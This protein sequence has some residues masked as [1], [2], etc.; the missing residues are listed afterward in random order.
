[1][2]LEQKLY[3]EYAVTNTKEKKIIPVP[4]ITI[5]IFLTL[6]QL[7]VDTQEY[8]EWIQKYSSENRFTLNSYIC[9]PKALNCRLIEEQ[10]TVDQN[11]NLE[12][13]VYMKSSPLT[14]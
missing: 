12:N 10:T 5:Q 9:W 11:T 1:M 6:F 13:L 2:A 14:Y 4:V 3:N 8:V 7:S